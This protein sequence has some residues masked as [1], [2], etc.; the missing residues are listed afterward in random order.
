VERSFGLKIGNTGDVGIRF[1]DHKERCKINT[2]ISRTYPG[3]NYRPMPFVY[4]YEQIM[5]EVFRENQYDIF[6]GC[7]VTHLEMFW[8][9]CNNKRTD[10]EAFAE[11]LGRL[12][13]IFG[14]WM[15]V[16]N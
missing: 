16:I 3:T 7:G 13:F 6:C 10:S 9:A 5:H 4:L 14:A 11:V 2:G 15:N 12:D 1:G 8:F